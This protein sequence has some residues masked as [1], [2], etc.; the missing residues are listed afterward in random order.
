MSQ[1]DELNAAPNG[2]PSFIRRLGS[3]LRS[4]MA[5]IDLSHFP[6]SCCT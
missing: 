6:G 5:R 4:I 3:I 2:S 1:M